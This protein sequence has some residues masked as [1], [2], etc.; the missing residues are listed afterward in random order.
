M[1]RHANCPTPVILGILSIA[2]TACDTSAQQTKAI[3]DSPETAAKVRALVDKTRGQMK[4]IAGG[5]FWLGD[6]GVTMPG[7]GDG[8]LADKPPD[9]PKMPPADYLPFTE[10]KDNKPPRWVTFTGFSMQSHKVTYGDFDVYVAANGLPAHPPVGDDIF[11]LVWKDARTSDDIPAG[12][13]WPQAKAYCQW[14]G[15]VT[16]LPFDLP[17]EAQWEFAASNRTNSAAATF[18]TLSGRQEKGKTHPTR[19]QAEEML[20]S[21]G[22]LYPVGRYEAS[23]AGLHDLLGNGP[24]WTNDWYAENGYAAGPSLNPTGPATGTEKV[25]RG[26]WPGEGFGRM[27]HLTRRHRTPE[28][29]LVASEPYP[30]N[31]ES[32]RCV[33]NQAFPIA[34]Q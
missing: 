1:N 28:G 24:D 5:S 20:G 17:T 31:I 2:L 11:H 3:A 12:V 18:P 34:S 22:V 15:K 33:L 32:F 25:I 13:A 9:G 10:Y 7:T 23:P 26:N 16:G 14:L 8:K 21:H 27:P 30:Y 29:K 19:D 6:F 4:F